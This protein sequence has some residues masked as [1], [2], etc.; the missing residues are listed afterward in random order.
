MT[1]ARYSGKIACWGNGDQGRL[2]LGNNSGS[3]VPRLLSAL[4]E[5]VLVGVSCGGAHTAAVAE[6]GSAFLWGLNDDGQLV[7]GSDS[8]Y[9]QV[10]HE[11]L[12]PEAITQVACGNRHTLFLSDTSCVWA[13]GDNKRGQLGLG[14]EL[15]GSQLLARRIQALV[16]TKI[17]HIAAGAEHSMAVSAAGDLFTWGNGSRGCLG[18]GLSAAG[19]HEDEHSPRLVRS[20]AGRQITFAAAGL[21][22][23][24]CVDDSGT[25]YIWG[26][27]LRQSF[28]SA[29]SE[30]D[31]P[32]PVPGIHHAVGLAVG[33]GHV[34][35]Q[36]HSGAVASYGA[37]EYGVLGH[38]S[39]SASKGMLPARISDVQF[40]QIACGW[41]HNAGV[42][43]GKVWT[44]GWGGSVGSDSSLL[45]MQ[46]SSGGQLGLG[47][48]FDYWRPT[49]ID[50]L[51]D[52]EGRTL[53][54]SSW[55]ALQVSCG[56]NHT[57]AIVAV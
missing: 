15:H 41:R 47:N 51:Q 53:P 6:D 25:A 14:R 10:P 46:T 43:D 1:M 13:A 54:A 56:M 22:N 12:I 2:G 19:Y 4:K 37:N 9:L 8:P 44:W 39:D 34:L 57:A 26:P 17:V 31:K 32:Q 42:A 11:A 29:S 27:A 16:G 45:P 23:S 38:G 21:A 3:S 5:A 49:V 36:E 55:S 30:V 33:G 50:T 52:E 24:G 28:G 20:L 48:E 35:V 18:H 7:H 40:E